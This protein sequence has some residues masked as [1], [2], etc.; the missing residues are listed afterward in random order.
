MESIEVTTRLVTGTC[1]VLA[2]MICHADGRQVSD[3]QGLYEALAEL[4]ATTG[5]SASADRTIWI[6]PGSYDV[7]GYNMKSWGSAGATS[8]SFSHLALSRVTIAGTSDNPRDTVIY[9][10]RTTGILNCYLANLKNLTV[11]NGYFSTGRSGPG[12]YSNSAQCIHSN[13]VVT[14]CATESGSGGGVY[15]G[16]WYDSTIA[17]NSSSNG[18]GANHGVYYNC[19]IV[20]NNAKS[21]GGGVYYGATLHNCHVA[22]NSASNGGGVCG[23]ASTTSG[24]CKIYG[25]T[26]ANNTASTSGGGACYGV[27]FFG[28]TVVSSNSATSYGGGIFRISEYNGFA[29]NIV[30]CCNSARNGGGLYTSTAAG[31]I[32]SNNVAGASTGNV[33]GGGAC[34]ST[35]IDSLVIHNIATNLATGTKTTAYGG[36]LYGGTAI[37]STPLGTRITGNIAVDAETCLGGGTYGTSLTNCLVCNNVSGKGTGMA[38]GSAYGCVISNNV[39]TTDASANT[40]RDLTHLENCDVVG[41]CTIAGLGVSNCRFSNFTNGAYIA[42]GEN[43]RYSGHFPG[44]SAVYVSLLGESVSLTNCLV[45][46]NI[47]SGYLFK[48]GSS[49]GVTLASCTVADNEAYLT[50]GYASPTAP[51]IIEN[52]ILAGN[53]YNSAP[54]NLWY[55]NEDNA[56]ITLVNNLIGSGRHSQLPA[57]ETGT[58]SSDS[59]DFVMDGT[60]DAYAL[61]LSSP[62]RRKGV[63]RDW[64]ANAL[65]IRQDPSFPRLRENE[66]DIGCYQCWLTK[67][68]F[69]VSF[70]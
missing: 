55:L 32:I 4:N 35:I 36:G 27:E 44:T 2:A 60:R 5:D 42:E 1:A 25:G 28:G 10:D 16:T 65:D 34:N 38:A 21:L 31:C 58:I 29:S 37:G 24:H 53:T 40:L 26:I 20:G 66:V 7:S 51:V 6:A 41:Y 33:F 59:P 45:A 15:H 30:I 56:Y 39:S 70:R 68:G 13:V 69:S 19:K 18:G 17:G 52:S 50:F 54:R 8:D 48:C 62:A 9:G 46:N 12:V 64:M 49:T 3:A 67:P 11:S 63:V 23:P 61:K 57:S 47:C 22:L 43:I 14:C